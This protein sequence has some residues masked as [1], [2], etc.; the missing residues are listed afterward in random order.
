ML[1]FCK[2]LLLALEAISDLLLC[3][4]LINMLFHSL[5]QIVNEDVK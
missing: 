4:S 2:V 1:L 5:V 3:V